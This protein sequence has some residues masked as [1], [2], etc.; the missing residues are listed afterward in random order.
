[1]LPVKKKREERQAAVTKV[2]RN[3]GKEK[4]RE[5]GKLC[6]KKRREAEG[7][8][9]RIKYSVLE[10]N[11]EGKATLR[12]LRRKPGREEK[13]REIVQTEEQGNIKSE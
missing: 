7:K 3:P 8:G 10:V 1:M 9:S 13:R 5:G 11:G 2:Q 12:K 4:R 6:R